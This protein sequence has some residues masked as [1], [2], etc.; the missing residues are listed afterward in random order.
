MKK[1]IERKFL[2]LND[3]WKK[4]KSESTSIKQAYL[5]K[6][7]NISIRVRIIDNKQ[8][9]LCVKGNM[10]EGH[11]TRAEY[12]YEIPIED[13]LYIFNNLAK[14]GSVEKTRYKI[15][16]AGHI[17]E[18]DEFGGENQGLVVT[19]IELQDE[20]EAIDKPSWLGAE[21]SHDPKYLN[22][23]LAV[24][25]Y[26]KWFHPYFSSSY[27]TAKYHVWIR[28]ASEIRRTAI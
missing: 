17:L 1:E 25:P 3:D 5:A 24:N 18:V 23:S 12:E 2:V 6:D 4:E 7:K 27:G 16:R 10:E 21:V 9:L 26:K 8:G 15:S 11:I 28:T 20:N 22:S 13:A 14:V 19:E